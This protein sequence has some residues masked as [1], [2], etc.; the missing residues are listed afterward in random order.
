M[1][2]LNVDGH[3][4]RSKQK[5]IWERLKQIHGSGSR[6]LNL[7]GGGSSWAPPRVDRVVEAEALGGEGLQILVGCSD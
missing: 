3:T 6:K 7:E 5:R 4:G 1:Q 2:A